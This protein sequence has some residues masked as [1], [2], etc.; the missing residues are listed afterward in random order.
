MPVVRTGGSGRWFGSVVRVGGSGRCFESV[1][2]AGASSRW[3]GPVVRVP[4]LGRDAPAPHWFLPG[5][6]SRP[7]PRNNL[8]SVNN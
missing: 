3:F 4:S 5:L 1:V 8:P 6:P 7:A 2:R